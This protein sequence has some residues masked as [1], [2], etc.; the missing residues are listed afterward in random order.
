MARHHVPIKT[1][2]I[3]WC[4]QGRPVG[5][6]GAYTAKSV[7]QWRAVLQAFIT[8]YPTISDPPPRYPGYRPVRPEKDKA[9]MRAMRDHGMAL[10]K[11]GERFGITES[12]VSRILSGMRSSPKKPRKPRKFREKIQA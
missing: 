5:E 8:R 7:D 9:E 3:S 12:G 4:E 10:S 1:I 11:I 2:V 6:W